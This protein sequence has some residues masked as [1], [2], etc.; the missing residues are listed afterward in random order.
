MVLF[1]SHKFNSKNTNNFPKL[2]KRKK[3]TKQNKIYLKLTVK[4][5]RDDLLKQDFSKRK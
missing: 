4:V 5:R 3:S 1:G 2:F